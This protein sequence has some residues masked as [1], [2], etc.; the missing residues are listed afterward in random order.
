MEVKGKHSWSSNGSEASGKAVSVKRAKGTA[1]WLP[2]S[3]TDKQRLEGEGA[4]IKRHNT[5]PACLA[6][7]GLTGPCVPTPMAQNG[8]SA[9]S[10]SARF[11]SW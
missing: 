9:T 2:G 8:S 6:K 7:A 4:D 5:Q 1:A 10:N 11:L 3:E